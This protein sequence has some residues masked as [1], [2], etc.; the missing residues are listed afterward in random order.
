MPDSLESA[1]V[2]ELAGSLQWSA[3]LPPLNQI[4]GTLTAIDPAQAFDASTYGRRDREFQHRDMVAAA[5]VTKVSIFAKTVWNGTLVQPI[6]Q[7][8]TQITDSSGTNVVMPLDP[9][10]GWLNPAQQQHRHSVRP[11]CR[12]PLCGGPGDRREPLQPGPYVV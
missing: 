1:L 12:H 8:A 9:D 11:Q 4:T 2:I 10:S 6:L 7:G 3:A 5:A